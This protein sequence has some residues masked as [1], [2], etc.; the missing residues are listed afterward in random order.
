MNDWMDKHDFKDQVK[1][2]RFCLTL[3]DKLRYGMNHLD[4]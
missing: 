2:Q 1:V 3:V 4:Q